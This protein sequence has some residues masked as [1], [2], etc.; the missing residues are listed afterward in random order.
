MP[1]SVL[2]L[3]D[4]DLSSTASSVSSYDEEEWLQAQREWEESIEQLQ[5]LVGVVLLPF[6]GKWLGRK[7]SHILYGRY[8]EVGF[9]TQFFFGQLFSKFKQPTRS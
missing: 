9:G 8:L 7:W 1:H 4:S 2:S 5:Q 6:F 3:D